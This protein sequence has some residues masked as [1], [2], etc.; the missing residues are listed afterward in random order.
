MEL[1]TWLDRSQKEISNN[2]RVSVLRKKRKLGI[3]MTT[4][5]LQP[6]VL[7]SEVML[8]L[9]NT[10]KCLRDTCTYWKFYVP[11]YVVEDGKLDWT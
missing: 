3:F 11:Q 2:I 6:I 8:E 10:V 4:Y 1:K 9:D 7:S 5:W